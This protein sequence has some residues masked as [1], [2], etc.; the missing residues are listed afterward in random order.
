VVNVATGPT[1]V[2]L[3]GLVTSR[4]LA[5]RN[6]STTAVRLPTMEGWQVGIRSTRTEEVTAWVTSEPSGARVEFEPLPIGR[7]LSR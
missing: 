2:A 1:G 7:C 6:P 5:Q 3:R 4:L